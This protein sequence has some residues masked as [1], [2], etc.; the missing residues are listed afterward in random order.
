MHAFGAAV[1]AQI[2]EKLT[3]TFVHY[4]WAEVEEVRDLLVGVSPLEQSQDLLVERAEHA[5]AAG[6]ENTI[7]ARANGI[8]LV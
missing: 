1:G 5:T 8:H 2:P 7:V 6:R 4:A 3:H